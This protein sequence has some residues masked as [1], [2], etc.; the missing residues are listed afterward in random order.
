MANRDIK[1]VGKLQTSTIDGLYEHIL[2]HWQA[3]ES[4]EGS[5]VRQLVSMVVF[6][7]NP[8]EP[9]QAI[10]SLSEIEINAHPVFV[11]AY[12]CDSPSHTQGGRRH[13]IPRIII[14]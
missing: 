10:S 12:I 9:I 6:L 1:S 2:D 14:P 13:S 7:R 8:L 11:T 3:C 4:K 5:E